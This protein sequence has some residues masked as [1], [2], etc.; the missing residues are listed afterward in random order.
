MKAE[1]KM[2]MRQID[3]RLWVTGQVSPGEVATIAEQGFRSLVCNRPD[4]EDP[5]QPPFATI[6]A[7][8]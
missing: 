7:A 6:D 8:G 3:E 2:D 4:G 5:A 1:A